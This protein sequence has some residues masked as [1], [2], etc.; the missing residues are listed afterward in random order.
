MI[1]TLTAKRRVHR[2]LSGRDKSVLLSCFVITSFFLE[3]HRVK[4]RIR[5][6]PRIRILRWIRIILMDQELA[7]LV[8]TENC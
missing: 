2:V 1:C 7:P 8:C 6:F 3:F 4:Q 5:Y